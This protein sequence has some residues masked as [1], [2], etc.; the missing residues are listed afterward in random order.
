DDAKRFDAHVD[1]WQVE[2]DLGGRIDN[3]WNAQ[4]LDQSGTRYTLGPRENTTRI[5][6]GDTLEIGVEVTGTARFAPFSVS[7]DAADDTQA[8]K[9]AAGDVAEVD[10]APAIPAPPS[11]GA[12][13]SPGATP[14]P[15]ARQDP[16]AAP[17]VV[18]PRGDSLGSDAQ[19]L[20]TQSLRY[21]DAPTGTAGP[22]LFAV[23]ESVEEPAGTRVGW[24]QDSF[25]PGPLATRGATIVDSAGNPARIN[26]VNWFGFETEIF[27]AHGLWAR[28]WQEIMDEVKAL[29]FNTMR[30]PFSGEFVAQGGGTPTGIDF[31]LNPDLEGLNGLQ[32][33]DKVVD[34]AHTIG[35][36]ILL[37]YHRGEPGGGPNDNGLWFGAGR[38]EADVIA[39]WQVMA[40][41]YAAA[42]AVIGADLINEP[43]AGTWGDGS[44]TDWAAA[45][46]RIG[47]AV[48]AVAPDWLIIV[49]GISQ[50]NGEPYW[51]GGNLQG[52]RD[53]PVTLDVPGRLVY[54]P[55]DYPASVFPQDWFFDGTNLTQKFRKMW[56]FIEEEG[57]A[58]VFLGEWGSRLETTL[59]RQWA[60]ELSR[61]LASHDIAWAWWSLNPNSDDTGGVLADDWSTVRTEVT[62]LLD[63][64]LSLTRP[65]FSPVDPLAD[66]PAAVFTIDL[67]APATESVVLNYATSDGTAQ[68]GLDYAAR[69]GTLLF[70]VGEQVKTVSVPVLPDTTAEGD[71]FFYLTLGD[72]SGAGASATAIIRDADEG[73][74]TGREPFVDVAST[75]IAPSSDAARFKIVLSEPA[76]GPVEVG[77][78]AAREGADPGEEKRGTIAIPAGA[79]EA[80]VEVQVNEAATGPGP[81]RTVLELVSA[82]G[83]VLRTTRA[84]GVVASEPNA[85]AEIDVAGTGEAAPRL[86]IDLVL[87]EDWGSGSLFNVILKN[88]SSTPVNA[89]Q[90]AVDLPF[91]LSELWSAVLVAD[92]GER[93]VLRNVEWNGT[94]LPGE[95][96]DFG[97][98]A[99]HGG[100]FLQDIIGA[101]DLELSVQ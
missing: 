74:L 55:H 44:A 6:A 23:G 87:E 9:P 2:V 95:A 18:L 36:R 17:P 101:A 84:T 37:D 48:L 49:E 34:Y 73:A 16:D 31:G 41:R 96:V 78:V 50:Y 91:D 27:V 90:L 56:G 21:L 42:P 4:I 19:M 63:P 8:P 72:T 29:G 76:K 11:P 45:A 54:S 99:D 94:I 10:A 83:A 1:G 71:E 38:T 86:T 77:F 7:A 22:G 13:P 85:A 12:A 98:V 51:W 79:R 100:I 61:Y 68:A 3:I 80:V 46:E 20:G 5:E 67:G 33:L 53:R 35:L 65:E 28:N 43:H 30:V 15:I 62:R 60:S 14:S 32:I 52:V 75:V 69:A 24:P 57:I 93:V 66:L 92:E 25:A 58:P 81:Q 70:S 64:F 59:D 88:T 82:E 26:G 89:W 39:E 40:T 47:N 97:F